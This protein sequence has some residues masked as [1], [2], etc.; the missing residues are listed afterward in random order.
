MAI[1]LAILVVILDLQVT[2]IL[3]LNFYGFIGSG[4]V[5]NLYLDTTIVTLAALLA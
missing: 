2:C 4:I 1:L 5:K 3:N